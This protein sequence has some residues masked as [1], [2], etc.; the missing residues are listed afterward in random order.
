MHKEL[1]LEVGNLGPDMPFCGEK[2]P[3]V[4]GDMLL[5]KSALDDRLG[6][7]RVSWC[8]ASGRN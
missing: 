8:N 5:R 2:M 3:D 6:K 1:G 7:D 4:E